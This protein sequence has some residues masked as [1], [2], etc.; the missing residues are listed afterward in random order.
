MSSSIIEPVRSALDSLPTA[1]ALRAASGH[2]TPK[3]VD[4]ARLEARMHAERLD[5]LL[6]TSADGLWDWNLRTD[7]LYC[8]QR[9]SQIIGFNT[10]DENG[11]STGSVHG[12]WLGYVLPQD[13]DALLR[14]VQAHLRGESPRFEHEYRVLC[15]DGVVRWVHS[16]GIAKFDEAGQPE[17]MV[18]SHRDIG[19]RKRAE[20]RIR[21]AQD[22][23]KR[24]EERFRSMIEH[25]SDLITLVDR[26][27]AITYVS[28]SSA[29]IL[30]YEPSELIGL[31]V[32]DLLH[33]DDQ[34]LA[35]AEAEMMLSGHEPVIVLQTRARCKDG[36]FRWLEV[37]ATSKPDTAMGGQIVLNSR[38]ITER[39]EATLLLERAVTLRTRELKTLLTIN[40]TVSS[41][42]D[43]SSLLETILDTASAVVEYD[44][45]NLFEIDERANNMR[46]LTHRGAHSAE[47]LRA[48]QAWPMT[49][50]ELDVISSGNPVII[51][52]LSMT[53]DQPMCATICRRGTAQRH[54]S[55]HGCACRS[56]CAT[57]CWV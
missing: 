14:G 23:I 41:R 8:S 25:G 34:S 55:S 36:G 11:S 21:E 15:N 3:Q 2:V 38:D 53:R 12:L 22:I 50:F 54:P 17:R 44:V 20:D 1:E 39:K 26:D 30:G 7:S 18:G 45:A 27:G 35:R 51:P 40:R 9:W 56:L 52:I 13:K 47:A 43:L 42:L 5:M 29:R 19:E 32:Y 24:N 28:P 4:D 57:A 31:H 48:L 37:V 49:R 10:S 33:A 6:Q 16:R 46:L